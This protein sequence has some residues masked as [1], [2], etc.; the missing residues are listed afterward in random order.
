MGMGA[1]L[2]ALHGSFSLRVDYQLLGEFCRNQGGRA[3]HPAHRHSDLHISALLFGRSSS[4]FAETREAYADAIERFGPDDFW[5]LRKG[6][7]KGYEY[8]AL[9]QI[10]ALLR[11]SGWD[12]KRFM[13]CLPALK[14][15]LGA[16]SNTQK[17][18]LV[19]AIH[20]VWDHYLPIGEN[21]D[22]A[23]EI[24]SILQ[25]MGHLELALMFLRHSV[26]LHGLKPETVFMLALCCHRLGRPQEARE[27]V[28]QELA[29]SIGNR[30]GDL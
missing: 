16:L 28:E 29:R 20:R 19:D 27:W 13:A 17:E 1:P 3:L 9:E 24:G 26:D 4:D 22:L 21:E 14:V 15:K 25:G 12:Y 6:L 7:E 5:I 8:F 2:P 10:L 23:F 18:D 30:Q 11:L